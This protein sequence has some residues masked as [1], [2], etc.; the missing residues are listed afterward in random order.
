MSTPVLGKLN[1]RHYDTCKLQTQL[2]GKLEAYLQCLC[3]CAA[4]LICSVQ[5]PIRPCLQNCFLTFKMVHLI[6]PLQLHALRMMHAYTSRHMLE[7]GS[8]W[9]I[10]FFGASARC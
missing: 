2:M 3:F 6:H 4:I 7:P 1:Q 5:A 10:V 9:Q 8:L